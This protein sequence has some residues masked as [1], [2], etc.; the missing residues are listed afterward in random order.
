MLDAES[1]KRRVDPSWVGDCDCSACG[2]KRKAIAALALQV[3][4][5]TLEWAKD[6]MNRYST[7]LP[8]VV[9]AIAYTRAERKKL[10]AEY[11]TD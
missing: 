2:C 3:Q 5:E 9:Q 11:G 8:D 7:G 4:A 6:G 10:E 1:V